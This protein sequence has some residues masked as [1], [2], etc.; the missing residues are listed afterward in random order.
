MWCRRRMENI[1]WTDHVKS[2]E[3]LQRVKA[4]RNNS[5]KNKKMLG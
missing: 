2:D 1:G 4:H 3:V 5:T